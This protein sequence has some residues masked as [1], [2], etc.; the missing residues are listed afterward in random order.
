MY[1]PLADKSNREKDLEKQARTEP[2][3]AKKK[4]L[5]REL[6]D[7]RR[8]RERENARI[9]AEQTRAEEQMKARIAVDQPFFWA[10]SG[11]LTVARRIQRGSSGRLSRLAWRLGQSI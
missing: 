5:Q 11:V 6:E 9:Q 2:D 1:I 3:A 4:A 8:A 10:T 7:L